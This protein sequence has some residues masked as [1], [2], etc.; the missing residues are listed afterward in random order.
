MWLIHNQFHPCKDSLGATRNLEKPCSSS[1]DSDPCPAP[2]TGTPWSGETHSSYGPSIIPGMCSVSV[3]ALT[4]GPGDKP[5]SLTLPSAHSD[6]FLIFQTL[7][8]SSTNTRQAGLAILLLLSIT[9][10]WAVMA[11]LAKGA[12][13]WAQNPGEHTCSSP[14][15][16]RCPCIC[17]PFP[18]TDKPR[19]PNALCNHF[20]NTAK[21]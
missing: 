18:Q 7:P 5:V 8:Y 21:Q 16:Q 10:G 15:A 17:M 2:T 9:T 13:S 14:N 11:P 20:T 3:S 4:V 1:E 12:D 6:P 19:P